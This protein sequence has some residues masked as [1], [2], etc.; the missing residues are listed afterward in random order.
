MKGRPT[1][2]AHLSRAGKALWSAIEAGY[3]LEPHHVEVLTLFCEARDRAAAA[4][5]IITA[6]G[7]ITTDRFG[8]VKAHP[9]VAVKRDAE[10]TAARL[11][12]ELDLD[13]DPPP[14]TR[15]PRVA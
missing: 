15:V 3:E 7:V 8:Q 9:A 4:Q 10:V 5:K 1:P 11:L 2:P 6:E 14:D 12:R 13:R